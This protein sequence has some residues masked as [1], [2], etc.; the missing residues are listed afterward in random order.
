MHSTRVL[1]LGREK[2]V[3]ARISMHILYIF[4]F[5]RFLFTSS[6]LAIT[7]THIIELKYKNCCDQPKINWPLMFSFES[8]LSHIHLYPKLRWVQMGGYGD[9]E[10]FI[11]AMIRCAN[12]CHKSLYIDVINLSCSSILL[13]FLCFHFTFICPCS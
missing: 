9:L 4:I 13:V 6:P 7:S 5:E 11:P 10:I 8:I 1:W 2:N 3:Y 12:K